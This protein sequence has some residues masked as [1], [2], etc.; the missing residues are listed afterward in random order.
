[1]SGGG[2]A[3]EQAMAGIAGTSGR[4]PQTDL[5]HK[6]LEAIAHRG[7]D[8]TKLHQAASFCGG[9]AAATLSDARGDGFARDGDVAVLFDGEVYNERAG[10]ASDAAVALELYKTYGRTFAAHLEG[11]FA[12][13]VQDGDGVLLARD[14][15]GVRPLYWGTSGAGD[16]CFASEAKALVGVCEDAAELPPATT[17]CSRSGLAGYV[18]QYP[19]V[20]VGRG[21]DEATAQV[22][23]A[24]MQAVARRLDDGAVGACLLSG[25]LDSSIIAAAAKALGADLPAVTVG[26]AGAPDLAN[27]ALVA[28]HLGMEHKVLNYTADEIAEIVPTAV[29]ALESFDEDCVSGAVSNLFASR[30]ARECT[31]C[32][33]SGEGGDEL[34]G[35]YHLLKELPGEAARLKMMGRLIEVAYNTAVQRLDRAMMF[36]GITYRTPFID[37]HV[38][39]LALQ[40]PVRWKIHPAADGALVEK[41]IL[42]EAF[43]DLLPETIYRRRKLRFSAGTGTDGLM[44]QVA[45]QMLPDGAFSERTRRT[46][47]GYTLSSPKEMWY[48]QLFKERFRGAGFE[49]LVGRWDPGK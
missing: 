26:L 48:Y 11:V 43:K 12:C 13:A 32:I 14:A 35:G 42:R 8:T 47:A 36:S 6:M 16:L 37:T 45:R 34:F 33:L 22:R 49:R 7:P 44:D 39:A 1:L 29:Y 5:V 31:N 23:Q 21:F 19:P 24:V 38:I 28:E 4:A 15:V 2:T 27:A 30:L 9:V 17:Y 10:G 18:S 20:R 3:L 25:G 41:H 46:P 40:L